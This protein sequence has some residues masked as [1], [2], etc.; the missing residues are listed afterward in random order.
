MSSFTNLTPHSIHVRDEAG[1]VHTFEPAGTVAR[2]RQNNVRVNNRGGFICHRVEYSEVEELGSVLP[3]HN[4]IVSGIALS[5]CS[6]R[7]DVVAPDTGPTC[8]RH[9]DGSINYSLGWVVNQ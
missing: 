5:K 7:T 8:K 9:P 3:D 6:D 2:V 4:Y 1:N